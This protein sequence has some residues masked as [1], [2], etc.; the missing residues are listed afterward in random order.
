MRRLELRIV[1]PGVLSGVRCP[2]GEAEAEAG[3]AE[4]SEKFRVK[5]GE[6]YLP[7]AE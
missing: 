1:P 3:M 7:V 2:F 4:M 5:G 6:M